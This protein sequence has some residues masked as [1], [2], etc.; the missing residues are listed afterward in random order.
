MRTAWAFRVDKEWSSAFSTISIFNVCT[1]SKAHCKEAMV[2]TDSAGDLLTAIVSYNSCR[3][4]FVAHKS[5]QV[6]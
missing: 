3:L 5:Q 1:V 4:S 2:D 6:Y